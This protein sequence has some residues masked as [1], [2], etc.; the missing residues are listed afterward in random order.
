MRVGTWNGMIVGWRALIR[1]DG[2]RNNE[3]KSPIHVYD[4]VRM[5]EEWQIIRGIWVLGLAMTDL[6]MW[7]GR[8]MVD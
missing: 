6:M 3:K 7:A 1:H 4:V 2:S 8:E 5:M